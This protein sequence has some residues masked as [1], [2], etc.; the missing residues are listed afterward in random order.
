VLTRPAANQLF[1]AN[2]RFSA[3]EALGIGLVD[4]VAE[5]V[6]AMPEVDADVISM[7][8]EMLRTQKAALPTHSKTLR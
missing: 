1:L 7:I 3:D 8:K 5:E 6:G 4:R 2:R